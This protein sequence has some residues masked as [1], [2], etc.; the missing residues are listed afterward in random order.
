MEERQFADR[1][2]DGLLATPGGA[3]APLLD[4][5]QPTREQLKEA[6]QQDVCAWCAGSVGR[7]LKGLLHDMGLA[8]AKGAIA[9]AMAEVA[10]QSGAELHR[11]L[12]SFKDKADARKLF[13]AC[14]RLRRCRSSRGNNNPKHI[15]K[16]PEPH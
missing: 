5:L 2:A 12:E 6:L 3:A 14:S 15:K 9:L 1:F 7:H 4:A 8:Q 11:I 13:K 10:A 16:Q